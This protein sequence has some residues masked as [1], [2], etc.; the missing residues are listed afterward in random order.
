MDIQRNQSI[1]IFDSGIGGLTVLREI[2]K[3][4]PNENIIYLGDTARVPYGIRSAETVIRYSIANTDFLIRQNIKIMIIAC[5]T[6]SSVATD[7]LK[8]RYSIPI[9]DVIGPGSRRALAASKSKKIGIIGTEG[10]IRSGAYQREIQRMDSESQT[11]TQA[12]PLFVPLAEEGWCDESDEVVLEIA[13]RYLA[14]LVDQ[15]IDTLVLG[16]THYP[17]LKE[18]IQK[19]MGPGIQ[20]VDSAEEIA[21]EIMRMLG[22]DGGRQRRKGQGSCLFFVTDIPHRFADTGRRFLGEE[23]REVNVVDI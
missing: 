7:V 15:Q 17:L 12:C 8:Q 5:N 20:L 6:A 3:H 22:D 11:Y 18:P 14:P 10:T 13:R 1:G 2:R 19:I 9:V 21:W 4:L 23:L 16:C